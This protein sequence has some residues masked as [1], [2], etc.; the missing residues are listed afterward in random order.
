MYVCP[1]CFDAAGLGR[2][3]EEIRPAFAWNTCDFHP[4]KKGV[5]V[6][7]VAEIIDPVFRAHYARVLDDGFGNSRGDD[8]WTTVSELVGSDNERVIE[9]IKN[10]LVDNDQYWPPD[11]EDAYYSD[12]Y[13]Y[14]SDDFALDEHGRLWHGFRQ[15]LMHEAR[16]FNDEMEKPLRRI[17]EGIQ[18]QRT[19]DRRGPVYLIQPGE[20]AGRFFRARLA[21]DEVAQRIIDN[22]VPEL[23]PPPEHL[24]RP[25]RMNPSGIA[26]FYAGFDL[27]TCISELRPLVGSGVIVG[28]FEITE[29]LVVLDTT[30]FEGPPKA[31]DPFA[32]NAVQR[33]A[34]WRFMRTFMLQIA[35]PVSPNDEH[36]DYVPTQVVAEYLARR[37]EFGFEGERKGF[38]AIIYRSAQNPE[39]R[40]IALFGDAARL[41]RRTS[42]ERPTSLSSTDNYWSEFEG[43]EFTETLRPGR[44]RLV[45]GSVKAYRVA[46]ARFPVREKPDPAH[47]RD[48]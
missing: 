29:P 40:N 37:H 28:E 20:A 22:P 36:L 12:E 6:Y 2:R 9:R 18:L 14:V 4:R 16:F 8:L 10:W 19:V 45:P 41:V 23:G 13:G 3:I 21:E 15:R 1:L 44:L 38:D 27:D 39:G 48:D 47:P 25:G 7:A 42:P 24:R 11:G 32:K 46:A 31:H 17:F 26:V 30:R 33:A 5:P 34:Q 43:L 35:Q